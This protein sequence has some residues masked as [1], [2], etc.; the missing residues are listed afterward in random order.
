[1]CRRVVV[2]NNELIAS[3]LELL[4][5]GNRVI[6]PTKGGSMRPFIIGVR[7]SVELE[8]LKTE[9]AKGDIV[10]ALLPLPTPHYVIHR[11]LKIDGDHLTLMGDGN[12]VGVERCL[13]SDVV[14]RVVAIITPRRAINPYSR[15]YRLYSHLWQLLLPIRRHLLRVLQRVFW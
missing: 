1:M 14:A 2:P 6:L 13:K 15:R 4:E 12:L 8:L 9:I 7:D 5:G 3:A 11:V 10:L